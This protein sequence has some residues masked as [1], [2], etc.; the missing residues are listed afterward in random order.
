MVA[1]EK[2]QKD[3]LEKEEGGKEVSVFADRQGM[4][5]EREATSKVSL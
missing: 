1:V 4:K 5:G 2:R 3:R